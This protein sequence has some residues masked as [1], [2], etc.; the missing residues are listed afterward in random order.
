MLTGLFALLAIIGL[1][2][3]HRGPAIQ[4]GTLS[5]AF[6]YGIVGFIDGAAFGDAVRAEKGPIFIIA[7]SL[8]MTAATILCFLL[9]RSLGRFAARIMP[10]AGAASSATATSP[11]KL[12]KVI[13]FC[14]PPLP[15]QKPGQKPFL[16]RNGHL[17]AA[18]I[19]FLPPPGPWWLR[20]VLAIILGTTSMPTRLY[21]FGATAGC[22]MHVGALWFAHR[23][24]IML[25]A[26]PDGWIGLLLLALP[27]ILTVLVRT[28]HL[29]RR[30][31]QP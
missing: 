25:P 14:A 9:G 15:P 1:Y 7:L 21:I 5:D 10:A 12:A 19:H 16:V 6:R 20:I 29:V 27:V 11:G 18:F 2:L 22:A 13:A 28:F 4:S 30:R 17:I 3:W 24:G 8:G 23:A 26:S 31:L